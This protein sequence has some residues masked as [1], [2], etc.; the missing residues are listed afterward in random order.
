[1]HPAFSVIFFTV[2]SGAGYGLLACAMVAWLF[3]PD[4]APW[5]VA[6]AIGLLLVV[7]GLCASTAHLG[8]PERAWRAFSQWR[9]SW[10]SR[11][12]VAAVAGFPVLAAWTVL[13]LIG[14]DPDTATRLL[15]LL[16]IAAAVV[17]TICTGM[18]YASL[19]P[20]RRW[21]NQFTVPGYLLLAAASGAVLT[22]LIGE[23]AGGDTDGARWAALVLLAAAA[24]LK[25]SYWRWCA[26]EGGIATI[27]DATGLGARAGARG[28]VKLLEAPHTESNY[29]T[30]EMGFRVARKHAERLRRIALGAGF[31][32]PI[33]CLLLG[34][35]VGDGL[36]ATIAALVAVLGN[37]VG[38]LTERWL[39]F[40]EARHTVT[41]YYGA[42]AA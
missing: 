14:R 17:T 1:M 30:D 42:Q 20:I 40:A 2:T 26:T 32:L 35:M 8:R 21:R 13:V 4:A 38:T 15:A 3:R 37:A 5:G 24:G 19:K 36:V 28:P 12:G 10:L 23:A 7:A 16:G 9:T 31:L 29:L 41:L 33:G 27:A 39:F 34:W 25:L 22:V 11:E 18:I 6:G